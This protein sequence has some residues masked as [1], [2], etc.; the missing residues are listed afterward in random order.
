MKRVKLGLLAVALM[1]T[2]AAFATANDDL[3]LCDQTYV[4]QNCP[5]GNDIDCCQATEDIFNPDMSLRT[6]QGQIVRKPF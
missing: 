3:D 6:P 1:G 4:D 2:I 5:Q